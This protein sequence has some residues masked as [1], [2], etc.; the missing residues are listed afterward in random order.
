MPKNVINKKKRLLEQLGA[1]YNASTYPK[2]NP[3]PVHVSL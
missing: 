2:P 1:Q 3:N